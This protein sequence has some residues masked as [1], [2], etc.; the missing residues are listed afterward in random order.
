MRKEEENLTRIVKTT[1]RLISRDY[2][3]SSTVCYSIIHTSKIFGNMVG[4]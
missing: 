1:N 4:C 3:T 2:E